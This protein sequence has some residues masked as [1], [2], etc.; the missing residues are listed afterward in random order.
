MA[1]KK[2]RTTGSTLTKIVI[3]V[4]TA[5]LLAAAVGGWWSLAFRRSDRLAP[6]VRIEGVPVGGL[7]GAE[8]MS[9]LS[10]E[11]PGA[12]P[13]IIRLSCGADTWD[14]PAEELGINVRLDTAIAEALKVGRR[15]NLLDTAVELLSVRFRGRDVRVPVEV[16]EERLRAAIAEL[17]RVVN[18]PPADARVHVVNGEVQIVPEKVGR[19]VDVEASAKAVAAAAT[20]PTQS[21]VELVVHTAQPAIKAD[22]LRGFDTVLAEYSTP[23]DA[24]KEKRTHNLRLGIAKV[25]ETVLLPGQSFSLNEALGP[26]LASRGW[27]EA[28]TFV[29]G[30]VVNTPGGG[31]CQIA[32]TLYNAALLAGL[33]ITERHAHSMPVAYV[34]RGRDATVAWGGPDLRFVNNLS[35]PILIL[36]WTAGN[37]LYVRIIGS[38]EDKVEVELVRSGVETIPAGHKE[39]PDPSLPPGKKVVERRGHAGARATL[40]RVIKRDGEE[41]KREVLHTDYYAPQPKVVRVGP[42]LPPAVTS[43]PVAGEAQPARPAT[44]M[45]GSGATSP[46]ASRTKPPTGREGSSPDEHR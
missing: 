10:M 24:A 31:V 5:A 46:P 7:S 18:R 37:R 14:K 44:G 29:N 16:D 12:R 20:N 35:H 13:R 1:R 2:K 11:W 9:K 27:Q 15:G 22:D 8:A 36:G 34:P 26:R 42:A 43:R 40:I 6:G 33:K 45:L 28:P 23:F 30:E 17:A 41:V 25:N 38:K 19:M 4:L 39:V 21:Q 3:P 32:T